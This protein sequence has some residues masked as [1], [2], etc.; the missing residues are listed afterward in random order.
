MFILKSSYSRH[1]RVL[2]AFAVKS[3]LRHIHFA[4]NAYEFKGSKV[5]LLF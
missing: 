1:F 3:R 2:Q 5:L 4:Y